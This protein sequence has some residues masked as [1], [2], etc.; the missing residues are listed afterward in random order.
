[1]AKVS[2]IAPA[3]L[4]FSIEVS[5]EEKTLIAKALLH[6]RNIHYY[7]NQ[8]L[9]RPVREAFVGQTSNTGANLALGIIQAINAE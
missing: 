1:M 2:E 5:E 3:E 9:G 8:G 7:C 6:Y 4:R